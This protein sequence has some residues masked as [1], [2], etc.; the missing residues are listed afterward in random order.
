MMYIAKVQ[1]IGFLGFFRGPYV[2]IAKGSDINKVLE[3]AT[4]KLKP[5]FSFPEDEIFIEE[6]KD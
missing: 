1:D 3:E 2:V 6:R 5:F 4:T